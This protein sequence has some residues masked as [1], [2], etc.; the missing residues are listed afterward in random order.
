MSKNYSISTNS[1]RNENFFCPEKTH[2]LLNLLTESQD[3][4]IT[5]KIPELKKLHLVQETISTLM[6]LRVPQS[7]E[8]LALESSLLANCDLCLDLMETKNLIHLGFAYAIKQ[9]KAFADQRN[10]RTFKEVIV[11]KRKLRKASPNLLVSSRNNFSVIGKQAK[12]AISQPIQWRHVKYQMH[13]S[14]TYQ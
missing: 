10:L 1:A 7:G 4:I 8:Q 13:T 11:M 5:V 6:W 14:V 2:T 12:Q 3:Q 9:M